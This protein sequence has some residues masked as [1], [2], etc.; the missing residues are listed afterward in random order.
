MKRRV[1]SILIAITLFVYISQPALA[2]NTDHPNTWTNTGNLAYD[3]AKIAETQIGYVET[4]NNQTKYNA[5]F[6]G[7]DRSA[8]WCAIFISWCANQAGVPASVIKRQA[9]ATKGSFGTP[10]YNYSSSIKQGDIAYIGAPGGTSSSHVGIVTEVSNGYVYTVEGNYS[11]K[12]SRGRFQ[13]STGKRLGGDNTAILFYGRPNYSG[14]GA[15]SPTY[16][17]T[18]S[19]PAVTISGSNVYVS[20]EY[21]GNGSRIDVHLIQE[22]WGWSDIKSTWNVESTTTSV[23]FENVQPG[24]YQ[25]FTIVRPNADTVQSEWTAFTVE[26]V[27]PPS[28]SGTTSQPIVSGDTER[29]TVSFSYSGSGTGVDV[30]LVL[31]SGEVKYSKH[32]DNPNGDTW[33]NFFGLESGEYYAYT[34]VRPN[35]DSVQSTWTSF[36]VSPPHTAH[37]K[38]GYL[39]TEPQHPHYNHWTCSVCGEDFTDGSTTTDY[40]CDQCHPAHTWDKGEIKVKP[41]NNSGGEKLFTCTVCGVTKTEIIPA[42]GIEPTPPSTEFTDVSAGAYYFEPVNWAVSKGITSGTGNNKF[43]PNAF[44]TRGQIATFLWRAAGSPEPRTSVN[45]FNVVKFNDYYYK[46]VLWAVENNITS[47]IG[48]GKF[49]PGRVCTRGQAVTFLWRAGGSPASGGRNSFSDVSPGSYYENAVNWAVMKTVTSGTGKGKFS[50]DK[51]CT[52]GQI[53]TFM[54]RAANVLETESTWEDAYCSLLNEIYSNRPNGYDPRFQL[55]YIDNDGIP[56]LAIGYNTEGADGRHWV[57]TYHDGKVKEVGH[58][59]N[60]GTFKHALYGNTIY[61]A[62]GRMGV[63]R[64]DFYEFDDGRAELIHALR[65]LNSQE[66][67][68]HEWYYELDGKQVSESEYR[69]AGESVIAGRKF[70]EVDYRKGFPINVRTLSTL[71]SGPDKLVVLGTP[72]VPHLYTETG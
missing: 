59:G 62:G 28:S 5:W 57:Y 51:A 42:I 10:T 38:G 31:P 64:H 60:Y 39:R 45:P 44:C 37:V 1:I 40:F 68:S 69:A 71:H 67:L 20:W 58:Y 6:Y 47:G 41:T 33:V 36:T 72:S 24:Y 50:P 17:G 14:G 21:K 35:D 4:G 23:C 55:I 8:G 7:S 56:E 26:A 66:N 27:Q 11:N 61:S 3:I 30:Y 43:S 12:V 53:V 2:Y 29:V 13:L 32:I 34:V 49:G 9:S 19:K 16:S 70:V 15:V 63:Y 48:G 65:V 46:A 54:Y 18:T 25:V 22:P 52:R